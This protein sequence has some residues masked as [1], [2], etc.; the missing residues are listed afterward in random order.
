MSKVNH[1]TMLASISS[2]PQTVMLFPAL[3]PFVLSS[4]PTD[5]AAS[6]RTA[7]S[8][9]HLQTYRTTRDMSLSP[10]LLHDSK[11]MDDQGTWEPLTVSTDRSLAPNQKRYRNATTAPPRNYRHL[12]HGEFPGVARHK[13]S[14]SRSRDPT[15]RNR[16]IY[17]SQ[18]QCKTALSFGSLTPEFPDVA[19]CCGRAGWVNIVPISSTRL[20]EALS[21]RLFVVR[22]KPRVGGPVSPP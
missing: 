12:L 18:W 14:S 21:E 3:S 8:H 19:T 22:G 13:Y 7:N 6:R 5:K 11:A 4:L 17:Q 16:P 2:M 9:K 1:I 10:Y 20:L 15:S